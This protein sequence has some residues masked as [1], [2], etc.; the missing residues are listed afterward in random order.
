[1]RTHDEKL[2]NEYSKETVY[3]EI[4]AESTELQPLSKPFYQMVQHAAL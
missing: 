4:K 2:K 3:E 1:M